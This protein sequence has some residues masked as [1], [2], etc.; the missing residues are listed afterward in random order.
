M[1]TYV[2]D[3]GMNFGYYWNCFWCIIITMTTVGYGDYYPATMP[4]RIVIFITSIWGVFLVSMMV[5]A[6]TNT[7]KMDISESKTYNVI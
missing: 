6:L 3:H 1:M 7:L 4:G 5:V 2:E